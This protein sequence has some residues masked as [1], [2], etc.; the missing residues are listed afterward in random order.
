[1]L[2]RYNVATCIVLYTLRQK[3]DAL[4]VVTLRRQGMRLVRNSARS[5]GSLPHSPSL[6]FW[7]RNYFFNFS[8][9]CIQNV[10]NTGTK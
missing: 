3:N 5:G 1:M 10:N 2:E 6:T 4:F 8:I 7:R 9:P